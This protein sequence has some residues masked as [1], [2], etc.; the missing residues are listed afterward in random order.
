MQIARS[1]DKILNSPP[2]AS[3]SLK[4]ALKMLSSPKEKETPAPEQIYTRGSGSY[5]EM[6]RKLWK[7]RFASGRRRSG[8]G[9]RHETSKRGLRFGRRRSIE[10]IGF[11]KYG[12]TS[13]M[14]GRSSQMTMAEFKAEEIGFDPHGLADQMSIT[15]FK[16][17]YPP[18][19]RE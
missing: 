19:C 11:E 6:R 18:S 15:E 3:L 10:G 4:R 8:V 16:H 9:T 2:S 7:P 5:F 12:H 1:K 14:T 13:Q 17:S